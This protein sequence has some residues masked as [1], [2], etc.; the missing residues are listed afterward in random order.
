MSKVPIPHG[1]YDL[2]ARL[3]APRRGQPAVVP[4]E[5]YERERKRAAA[6]EQRIAALEA[7]LAAAHEREAALAAVLERRTWKPIDS[8]PRD[9]GVLLRTTEPTVE[10]GFFGR[11]ST[12]GGEYEDFCIV[13]QRGGTNLGRLTVTHWMPIPYEM[14][15]EPTPILARVRREAKREALREWRAKFGHYT[16]G[17]NTILDEMDA[18][19]AALEQEGANL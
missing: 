15:L 18:A 9:I 2:N 6:A 17:E 14:T 16:P 1:P 3:S 10:I 5:C 7:E 13:G 8:V 4:V 11:V 12:E 19:L